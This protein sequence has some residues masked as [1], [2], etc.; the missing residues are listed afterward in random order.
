MSRTL[1]RFGAAAA[2]A[3][4]SAELAAAAVAPLRRLG[5][6]QADKV[7]QKVAAPNATGYV[8]LLRH[9][10][11]P[12]GGDPE[13][14]R[15]G[16]CTTQRNLSDEGRAQARKIGAWLSAQNVKIAGVESSRWCRATETAELLNLG[17]PRANPSLDSLFLVPNAD[18]HPQTQ[19]ARK[20]IANHRNKS[21]LLVLVGHQA[22]II[23]LTGVAPASGEGVLVKARPNGKLQVIGRS[24]APNV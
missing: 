3:L 4:L 1:R 8:L 6:Q 19:Q 24:P 2:G 15:L 17:K 23:A 21:G 20:Q 11:A 13:N 14:F 12:G 9:A 5:A 16:D 22:N 7:W 18:T 10:I